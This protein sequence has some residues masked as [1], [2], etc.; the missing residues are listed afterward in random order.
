[1]PEADEA[2]LDALV[3]VAQGSPGNALRF[4]GLDIAGLDA[5]IEKLAVHGDSSNALRTALGRA[6]SLKSAQARYEAFLERAPSR[7]AVEAKRGRADLGEAVALWR[8]ARD[9]AD[10]AVRQ[11]MDPQLTV[12]EIAG[13]VAKLAPMERARGS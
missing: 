1:L 9:I 12:V 13:L 5:A 10:R 8:Q 6:L 4:A 11:S 3:R 7:I 2:E